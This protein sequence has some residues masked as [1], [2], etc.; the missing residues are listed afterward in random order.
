M[1]SFVFRAV[2]NQSIDA[3]NWYLHIL[4]TT[5]AADGLTALAQTEHL[6]STLP[7]TLCNKCQR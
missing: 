5:L 6:R 4:S 7:S 1:N 3:F 2:I